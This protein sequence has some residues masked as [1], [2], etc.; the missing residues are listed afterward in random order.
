MSHRMPLATLA[1]VACFALL[2]PAA[3]AGHGS[4]SKTGR[5]G[6]VYTWSAGH[7]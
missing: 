5:S 6:Q 1:F 3:D 7:C 4:Y 2:A